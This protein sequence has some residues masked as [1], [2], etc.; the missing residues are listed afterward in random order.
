MTYNRTRA[1]QLYNVLH[2][3]VADGDV[4]G[5]FVLDALDQLQLGW[6][7]IAQLEELVRHLEN[8]VYSAG[9]R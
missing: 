9:V 2:A 8:R 1:E 5:E 6:E 3:Q 7:R 4:D